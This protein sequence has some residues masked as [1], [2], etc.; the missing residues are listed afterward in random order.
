MC[1]CNNNIEISNGILYI[2]MFILRSRR[3]SQL[4]EAM[5]KC[6]GRVACQE[7]AS[8]LH[9]FVSNCVLIKINLRH[10]IASCH[11]HTQKNEA[12]LIDS[13]C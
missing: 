7:F 1:I 11:T 5:C 12:N 4:F 13:I 2:E 9:A 10:G 3:P 8:R 6:V